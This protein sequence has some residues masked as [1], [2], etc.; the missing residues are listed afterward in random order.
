MTLAKATMID[1]VSNQSDFKYLDKTLNLKLLS[2]ALQKG[3]KP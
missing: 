2:P 1:S 3:D